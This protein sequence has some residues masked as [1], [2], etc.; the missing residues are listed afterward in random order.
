MAGY[1]LDTPE[2]RNEVAEKWPQFP[3]VYHEAQS[4]LKHM[5]HEERLIISDINLL[6]GSLPA[7]EV[8]MKQIRTRFPNDAIVLMA[9]NAP[10]PALDMTLLVKTFASAQEVTDLTTE[11]TELGQSFEDHLIAEPGEVELVPV[12]KVMAQDEVHRVIGEVA[13]A[14]HPNGREGRAL[15][16]AKLAAEQA[17]AYWGE[18]QNRP[19]WR[20]SR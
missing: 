2:G 14:V 16:A 5:L 12:H 17:A 3:M 20:R 10:A 19:T 6:P 1:Y 9:A 15:R 18:S 4:W 13:P 8:W 7:L 11:V